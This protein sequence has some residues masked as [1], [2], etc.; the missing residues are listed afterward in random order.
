ML[1]LI[2]QEC[3]LAE[4][5]SGDDTIQLFVKLT[6]GIVTKRICPRML[7]EERMEVSTLI[8]CGLVYDKFRTTIM[9]TNTHR[10]Y[11]QKKFNLIRDENEGYCK[12]IEF[13]HQPSLNPSSLMVS[14]SNFISLFNLDP[15]RVMDLILDAC[16]F[17]SSKYVL[18][19]DVLPMFKSQAIPYLLKFK[20]DRFKKEKVCEENDYSSSI[21]DIDGGIAYCV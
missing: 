18:F 4:K 12:L 11:A 9:R 16:E 13:L 5:S 20:V 19:R 15:N 7:L 6:K 8:K 1:W 21:I 10:Y 14:I 2:G 17:E 3:E